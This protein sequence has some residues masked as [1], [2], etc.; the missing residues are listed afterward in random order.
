MNTTVK[1]LKRIKF[2]QACPIL[3]RAAVPVALAVLSIWFLT[4]FIALPGLNE[5]LIAMK[6]N[7]SKDITSTVHELLNSYQNRFESGELT[8]EKAQK[9]AAEVIRLIRYGPYNNDYFWINDMS[10]K[11]IM[12]PYRT[13]LEG[14]DLSNYRDPD[15]IYIFRDMVSLVKKQRQGFV[16]YKWQWMDDSGRISPKTSYIVLY[17]PWDWIVGTGIY[18]DD[19]QHEISDTTSK[20]YQIFYIILTL[21]LILSSIIAVRNVTSEI[22]RAAAEEQLRERERKYRSI[23]ENL[24]DVYFETTTDGIIL[25]L[26]PSVESL[27]QY[28]LEELLNTSIWDLYADDNPQSILQVLKDN[29]GKITDHEVTMLN[30]DGSTLYCSITAQLMEGGN[31]SGEFVCGTLRDITARKVA[32]I[33]IKNE[34]ELNNAVL[35]TTSALVMLLDCEGRI[36]QFNHACEK[37]SGYY[38]NE[39]IGKSAHELFL[40]NTEKKLFTEYLLDIPILHNTSIYTNHWLTRSGERRLIEWIN[41]VNYAPDMSPEYIVATGTDITER[42]QT[43]DALRNSEEQLQLALEASN[44]CILDYNIP[45]EKIYLSQGWHTMLSLSPSE[46]QNRI[47]TWFSR[48][49][50]EDIEAIRNAIQSCV[51]EK[52]NTFE[53]EHRLCTLDGRWLWALA[54][55]RTVEFDDTGNPSRIVGTITDITALKEMRDEQR[56]LLALIEKTTELIGIL[57]SDGSFQYLNESGRNMIGISHDGDTESIN[58]IDII[59]SNNTQEIQSS[60]THSI[61][62]GTSWSGEA[63]IDRLPDKSNIDVHINTFRIQS[64]HN[65]SGFATA[66]VISDISERKT[67]ENALKQSE[68][69]YRNIFS[70][71][72]DGIMLTDEQ[73]IIIEVNP[74]AEQILGTSRDE[75]T[76]RHV[77]EIHFQFM[78]ID[79]NTPGKKEKLRRSIHGLY[80]SGHIDNDKR[81][82]MSRFQR[83]DG[84][85][86]DLQVSLSSISTEKGYRFCSIFRDVTE[87]RAAERE[88]EK[89]EEQNRQA[90]KLQSIGQLAGG[91]AHD[92]NNILTVIHGFTEI[93]ARTVG[94]KIPSV[95]EYLSEVLKAS[96]RARGIIQQILSFS[97]KTKEEKIALKVSLIVK[98][99]IKFLRASLPTI[100]DIRYDIESDN[101]TVFAEPSQINQILMNLC[102]NAAYAMGERG[103]TLTIDMNT[104]IINAT[105]AKKY[106]SLNPDKYLS[107]RISDTG[108]GMSKEIM[109]RI[110]EPYF[111]TKPKGE[112]T[113]LGLAVVYGIVNSLNGYIDVRSETGQGT[114]FEILL[115]LLDAEAT[116]HTLKVLPVKT[117]SKA[118]VLVVDDEKQVASII[119]VILTEMGHEVDVFSDSTKA[120]RAFMASPDKY[121]LIVTDQTMPVMTGF[122]LSKHLLTIKPG[123]PIIICTG[124]S[125]HIDIHKAKSAGI[126]ELFYKPVTTNKLVSAISSVL[127]S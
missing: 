43:L 117:T 11:M 92:F 38:A 99:T 18:L 103:G 69:K 17:E 40:D 88:K 118:N 61:Q 20:L 70:Q 65:G 6:I 30:K 19:V 77:R 50:P 83:P 110:F 97:R 111:T 89:L 52:T 23:Y 112:G 126:R 58:L 49:H 34:H 76:G 57:Q 82:Q 93:A 28:S 121:D 68:E 42:Q 123:L 85:I 105:E 67:A 84:E 100:I 25:E 75:L 66:A 127:S 45:G 116:E 48:T 32:E 3:F 96:D 5:H 98:E 22:A 72:A 39:V 16:D 56:K 86:H 37:A 119:Y 81:F 36:Q 4:F 12:H 71:S 101:D 15:G 73:G 62:Q 109:E 90:Q 33:A 14:L 63:Q 115:P 60:I 106:T 1:M 124:Y 74:A 10:P 47:D 53:V 113:G 95:D 64:H 13:D 80:T 27:S 125:D 2:K 44:E 9:Q 35:D 41:T 108:P 78:T 87:L 29:N 54:R 7:T 21:V 120:L 55:G 91:I 26:S 79:R 114:T 104:V 31:Q 122:E 94:K 46:D 59:S 107:L 51:D 8:L 24:Q 102:T